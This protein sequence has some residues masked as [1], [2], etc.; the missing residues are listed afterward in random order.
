MTAGPAAVIAPRHPHMGRL[1]IGNIADVT[2]IDPAA[3]W[4]VDVS[5]FLSRSR[6]CPYDGWG[7]TGRAVAT[8]V[9]GKIVHRL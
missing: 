5:K 4:T 8:I 7:L 2:V 1:T 6:N 9:E 3:R